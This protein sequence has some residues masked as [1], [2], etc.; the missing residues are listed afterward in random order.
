MVSLQSARK[1]KNASLMNKSCVVIPCSTLSTASIGLGVSRVS[2]EVKILSKG[3][4][5]YDAVKLTSLASVDDLLAEIHV[6][7]LRMG[8]MIRQDALAMRLSTRSL[9]SEQLQL[10][11][12]MQFLLRNSK[13]ELHRVKV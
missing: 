8:R 13:V 4:K 7:E 6:V 3:V 5:S 1:T 12:G 10:L 9:D 11:R 2:L